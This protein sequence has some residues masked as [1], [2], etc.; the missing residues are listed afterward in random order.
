[1][2]DDEIYRD[3]QFLHSEDETLG[4]YIE[5][6]HD[7]EQF[8][9]VAIDF[10]KTECGMTVSEQYREAR[11]GYYKVIPLPG[12]PWWFKL[13]FSEQKMRGSKPVME[14]RYL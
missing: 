6:H 9:R 11:Q 2:T 13:H 1:M 4:C 10:L 14:M 8:K 7:I 12:K 5:G 3:M